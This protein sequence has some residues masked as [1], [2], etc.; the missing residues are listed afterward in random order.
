MKKIKNISIDEDKDCNKENPYDFYKF[1]EQTAETI[2]DNGDR[3]QSVKQN[4]SLPPRWLNKRPKIT[5]SKMCKQA[6]QVRIFATSFIGEVNY[7]T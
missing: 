4:Y 6:I 2:K 1:A 7:L 3:S 5:Y